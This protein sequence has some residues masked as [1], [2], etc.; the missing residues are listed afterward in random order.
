MK[1]IAS[2]VLETAGHFNH[3][4]FDLFYWKVYYIILYIVFCHGQIS[5]NNLFSWNLFF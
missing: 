5:K 1:K 3:D 4:W 2:G